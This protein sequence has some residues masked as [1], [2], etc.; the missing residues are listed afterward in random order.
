MRK[1]NFRPVIFIFSIM[2]FSSIFVII[3]PAYSSER[4]FTESKLMGTKWDALVWSK[5]YGWEKATIEFHVEADYQDL[6][7]LW[8]CQCKEGT[9]WKY[10]ETFSSDNTVNFF[11]YFGDPYDW[12]LY[13]FGRG[14]VELEDHLSLRTYSVVKEKISLEYVF[15]GSPLLEE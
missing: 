8:A 2:I 6:I 14:T 13:S 11:I 9:P 12:K 4:S 7:V 3:E 10:I 15:F 1:S 5:M